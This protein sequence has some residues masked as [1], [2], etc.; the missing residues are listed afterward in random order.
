MAVT[1]GIRRED[2]N[3]WE[4]RVPLVP[5]DLAALQKRGELDFRVQPS[6]IRV[7]TD[8]EYQ[9]AGITVADDLGPANII[10]AVKEIPIDLLQGG[11]VY[12]YFSHTIKG[13][14]YN[15]PSLRHLLDVGATLIDY[16]RIADEQNRRLIFF[17]LHAGYAGMIESLVGLGQRLAHLGR[18]TPLLD[19]KHPHEYTSLSEARES[20]RQIGHRI[21][22]S[23]MGDHRAPV[24]IGVAGYGNVAKG[25][26][27]I[28]DCLPV[29]EVPVNQL[30]EAAAGSV[31]QFG[32]LVKV[33]F[34]EKD[35]VRPRSAE[36]Q[37]VLQDYYEHPQNYR[38][39]FEDYL[40]HLDVLMNTIYWEERY[41][42][43]VTR[44]WA[45]SHYGEGKL[46]R[47]Q[48]I[49]DISCDI[50]G[51]IELTAKTTEPDQPFFVFDPATQAV[52]EGVAGEGPVIMAVDNLPCQ[53]PRESSEHFSSV[54]IDM[55]PDLARAD[56]SANF[57][58]LLLPSYLKK[59]VITH[60]GQLTPA[61]KY[62]EEFLG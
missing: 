1:I 49:G 16:E 29:R 39:V 13:Q 18:R 37:F 15:M 60:Q 25:C 2:K 59:A 21:Q 4:R 47:L 50:G 19:I 26:Q 8:E 46:P 27:D 7:F 9:A 3:Q 44:K 34:R 48:V 54:L 35:M 40:P 56:F 41:P 20:V 10:I 5:A 14:A 11:K 12:L 33:T 61:F 42:R 62:L 36:A 30:A 6:R 31:E 45:R 53:L 52:T 38:S 24:I 43:L 17:S 55:V 32:P 22:T 51:S 23:G 57:G 28:L 58:N